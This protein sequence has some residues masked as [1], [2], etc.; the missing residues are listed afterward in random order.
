MMNAETNTPISAKARR[1]LPKIEMNWLKSPW[2]SL[3]LVDW[4]ITSKSGPMAASIAFCTLAGSVPGAVAID[5]SLNP[6]ELLRKS[7]AVAESKATAVAP[8]DL[9]SLGSAKL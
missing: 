1:T 4:S 3:T 5:T 8:R 2:V 7:A 9:S 6:G